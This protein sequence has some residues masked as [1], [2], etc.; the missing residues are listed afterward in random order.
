MERGVAFDEGEVERDEVD[1][2]EDACSGAGDL[3]K[4]VYHERVCEEFDGPEAGFGCGCYA[5]DL[6]GQE[7]NH[8]NAEEHEEGDYGT[9]GPGVDGATEGD[10]H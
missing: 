4:H 1:W 8:E 3:E 6:L 5:E 10:G 7:N 9:A 2:D